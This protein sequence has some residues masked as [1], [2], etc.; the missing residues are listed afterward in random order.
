ML[1]DKIIKIEIMDYLLYDKIN[2]LAIQYST[3][4]DCLV[5]IAIK[6]LIDDVEFV[7]ELRNKSSKISR[8]QDGQT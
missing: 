8:P 4:V 7:R 1:N 6:R 2:A 5:N 3:T